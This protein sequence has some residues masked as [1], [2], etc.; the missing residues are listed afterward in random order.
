MPRPKGSKNKKL[1]EWTLY[2]RKNP[3]GVKAH[4]ATAATAAAVLTDF[5]QTRGLL[6]YDAIYAKYAAL[7]KKGY[8]CESGFNPLWIRILKRIK[9]EHG[10]ARY[11]EHYHIH[12]REQQAAKRAEKLAAIRADKPYRRK[13]KD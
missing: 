12:K 2:P 1:A 9:T 8:F 11:I 13:L 4:F 6:S 7:Y 5:K 10:D 3:E